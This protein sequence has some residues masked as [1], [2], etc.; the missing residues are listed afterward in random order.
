MTLGWVLF[1]IGTA[2]WLLICWCAGNAEPMARKSGKQLQREKAALLTRRRECCTDID[3]CSH[4]KRCQYGRTDPNA[5]VWSP[6]RA[7]WED[8]EEP[9]AD[10]PH[11]PLLKKGFI[12]FT[13]PADKEPQD[14]VIIALP[15]KIKKERETFVWNEDSE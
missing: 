8:H 5:S 11:R 4:L 12:G 13:E 9:F 10:R 1:I 15:A 3:T 6:A 14:C 7:E 2:I